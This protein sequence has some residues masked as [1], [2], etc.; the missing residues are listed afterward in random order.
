MINNKLIV[1]HSSPD[2]SDNP[3]ALYDYVRAHTDYE[4]FWVI[5]DKNLIPLLR[6]AGIDCGALEEERTWEKIHSAQ[7]LVSA[8]FILAGDK[9]EGQIHV[10]AWHGFGPKVI[11]FTPNAAPE[12]SSFADLKYVTMQCDLVNITSRFA[13][14]M[15]AGQFAM[16][17]RKVRVTGFP[18]NDYL[19]SSDGR[20]Y[21][22][23][24]LADA[25]PSV[26]IS[27]DAHLFLY[28]PTM[29]EGLKKEGAQFDSN[30]FNYNDYDVARIDDFLE[31]TNS[32]IVAKLHFADGALFSQDN[33][34]LPKRFLLLDGE[35]L[36]KRMLTIYH[37]MNAFD[38]LITD[39]SS[40]YTDFML[41]NRPI[42]FSC[43]DFDAYEAD[44]GFIMQDPT[45]MM[46]GPIVDSWDGL[47]EQ[48]RSVAEGKDDYA[49]TRARMMSLFHDVRDGNSSQRLFEAM[50]DIAEHG[51]EDADKELWAQRIQPIQQQ[52]DEAR[53]RV[54]AMEQSSSWKIT[55]PLRALRDRTSE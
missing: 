25:H 10:S 54:Q 3:R 30:P 13:Q 15:T 38:A 20:A 24:V 8:S 33:I 55:R 14:I 1:F 11:G 22:R 31:Q 50:L 42:V 7:F 6:D 35:A 17:R 40:A 16:D 52:L 36:T 39:Y 47:Q 21:V 43:P 4:T 5:H 53:A 51:V 49:D 41:L 23:E 45:L 26:D 34:D 2:F 19:F 37:V 27:D 46:P 18:R 48:L 29:R 44:R 28:L 12:D 9:T 32:Y